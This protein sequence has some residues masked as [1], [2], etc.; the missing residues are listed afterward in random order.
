MNIENLRAFLEVSSTGSFHKAAEK[1]HITQ[2]SVSA[3]IKA[4]EERLNR[5][6]F[7][8]T[9]HGVSLTSGGQIFYRHALSVIKTWERAQHEVSLP[10]SV[11]TSVSLGIPLNH[12]GNITADWLGWMNLN[13][14]QVATLV[15]S[16]Y[17]V[18]LMNQLREGLLDLAI[19]YE[20]RHWPDVVIE[21]YI[22]EKLMLVSTRPRRVE[23]G[24]D[25]GYVFIDWGPSFREQHSEAYPGIQ[26]H[27]LSITQETIAL[28][29]VLTHGGSAYFTE[30]MVRGLLASGTLVRVENAP[31]LKMYTYLVYSTLRQGEAEVRS[32]IAG[33]RAID[34]YTRNTPFVI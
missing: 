26:H 5:Q 17:S 20:P 12:W 24:Q 14:P 1:L 15:Q 34:Y 21:P 16:D 10:F 22:E 27:R 25:E 3:R 28:E 23:D 30:A 33:L 18:L 32:A 19:L 31:E 9:R 8:R 13:L 11:K 7:T 4:L 6:L 2:S 29:Y